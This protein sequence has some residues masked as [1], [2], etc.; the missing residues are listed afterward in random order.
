[1]SIKISPLLLNY[2]QL[3][4]LISTSLDI[5]LFIVFVFLISTLITQ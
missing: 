1:M 2:L 5:L 3:H 4:C